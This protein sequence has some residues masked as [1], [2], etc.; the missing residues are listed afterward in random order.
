MGFGTLQSHFPWV[1]TRYRGARPSEFLVKQLKWKGERSQWDT[2]QFYRAIRFRCGL[3]ATE[4][5]LAIRAR[6]VFYNGQ[7]H[8]S[9]TAIFYS[10]RR[11]SFESCRS[12]GQLQQCCLPRWNCFSLRKGF[13]FSFWRLNCFF[14]RQVCVCGCLRLTWNPI[15]V[16]WKVIDLFGD[17]WCWINLQQARSLVFW[18]HP[19]HHPSYRASEGTT[20]V[21]LCSLPRLST[22]LANETNDFFYIVFDIL[23][24]YYLCSWL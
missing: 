14:C 15:I 13:C 8:A 3:S 5:L 21:V 11:T 18:W 7:E 20:T 2:Q 24:F 16:M 1:R 23:C 9:D 22:F 6:G 12:V 17:V 4:S 19:H 10:G